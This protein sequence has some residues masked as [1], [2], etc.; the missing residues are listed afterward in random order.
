[1]S[2]FLFDQI[3]FGPVRS[4]RL[5]ISL[6][7][8]LLPT[9]RKWCNFDCLY[10]ECGWNSETG[11]GRGD[12]PSRELVK[13]MLDE[14]I[15]QME[16][17][18]NL[19]DVLTFA[20]NG[21]PTL[22]PDFPGIIE[23]TIAIRNKRCPDARIAVLSNATTIHHP[24]IRDALAKAD[25]NIL[26]LDSAI[27]NTF[28]LINQPA[29]K[30]TIDEYINA[31]GLFGKGVIIQTLLLRGSYMGQPV[32]NTGQEEIAA[33]IEAYKRIRPEYVMIYSFERD[34]P[35]PSLEK[36]RRAELERIADEIREQ[37]ISCEVSA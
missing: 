4:R 1:M 11:T 9:D 18:G 34:T 29:G 32:D 5:G 24:G 8:N 31:L 16:L 27:E 12:L 20:G 21:E 35:L 10:C 33:L 3:I 37:G 6:G 25:Q 19:P 17:S 26:K 30:R 2:T 7:I 23:D 13:E 14:K 28:R 36:I 22:H 15:A